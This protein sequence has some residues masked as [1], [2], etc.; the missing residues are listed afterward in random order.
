MISP[1]K[2][3]NSHTSRLLI[4][5]SLTALMASPTIAQDAN[6]DDEIEELVVWGTRV[7]S[8]SLNL[9]EQEIAIR[10]ADHLSDLLRTIPGVDIGGTHSVN[11][12]INFRGLDDRDLNVFID[13]ALQTNYLYHH[14][15]NLLINP[16]ILKSAD[17]QLGTNTVTHGG[18]GGSVRFDTK[19]A[20]D[21]LAGSN[22]DFGFRASGTY[23]TNEMVGF[24]GTAYGQISE[25][26]DF[27]GYF[28]HIDRGNFEDGMD[29]ETIGSDGKTQDLLLKVGVDIAD[30]Q[31]IEVSYD[32]LTDE[33]DYTQRP[34]MGV[35]TNQAITGDILLPTE[36]SR[37]SINA[38]YE[39]NLGE[40]LNL[41][42]TYYTNDMRLWRDES[43]PNIPRSHG[44]SREATS[45]NQGVSILAVSSFETGSVQHTLTYGID[46]F[47]QELLYVADTVAN[48][49]SITQSSKNLA[50]F[51]EDEIELGEMFVLRPGIRYTDY[52]LEYNATGAKGSWDDFN[53]GVAGELRFTEDF[54]LLASYT[55]LFR[56]P[57]LAEV[58]GGVGARTLVNPDVK[59]ETGRNLE[60]G[61]RYSGE[62]GEAFL[63]LG[64]NYF[65]THIDNYIGQVGVPGSTTREVWDANLGTAKIDG[66]E[67]SANLQVSNWDALVTFSNS[68]LD[69]EELNG[70]NLTESLREIGDT[71]GTE[72][73]YTFADLG[74]ILSYNAQHIFEETTVSN[75]VKKGYSIHN[76]NA[77]WENAAGVNGLTLIFG[78]DNLLDKT[79]TS[80]ASRT[81]DTFHPVFGPLHLNDI[82]PG[83]NVKFTLSQ[84]F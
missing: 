30:N 60:F 25:K 73:S 47:D 64:A 16:D 39:L 28:N 45:N 84:V 11:S 37:E 63:N 44:T 58:F 55:E 70:A 23:H 29:R 61:F 33:G 53:F 52:E 6:N 69:I 65:N 36:Y 62:I 19:D 32:N 7:K 76:I 22:R 9:G 75:Q 49:A 83:R 42:A 21:L 77:R 15:G 57:E 81:G 1:K 80:H 20:K 17:I 74:L 35:L 40:A 2:T 14:I 72:L 13:G 48:S 66:F 82:E 27:L 50:F 12:R 56:G 34:D 54:R 79:F 3:H 10:Q 71:L 38:R 18:L 8:N 68:N 4:S 41:S 59:P 31:R 46:Y 43:N 26:I 5:A 24:S 78:I 67:A 51:V